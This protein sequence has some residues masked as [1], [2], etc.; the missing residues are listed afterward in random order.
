M[1]GMLSLDELKAER[2][3]LSAAISDLESELGH[4]EQTLADCESSAA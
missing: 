3:T 2:D 4:V 1:A